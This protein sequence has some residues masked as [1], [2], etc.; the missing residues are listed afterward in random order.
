ME[1]LNETPVKKPKSK[2]LKIILLSLLAFI[3]LLIIVAFITAVTSSPEENKARDER[4]KQQEQK[5]HLEE[6]AEKEKEKK[7]EEEEEEKNRKHYGKMDALIQSQVYIETKLKSP[8][9]A[10]FDSSIDG[11]I[12]TNDTTFTVISYVDSQN[13][14]G[15]LLR[16]H[17]SC[18]IIFHPKD[19]THDI[20]NAVIK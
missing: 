11:V 1:Q 12:Q 4:I 6:K 14:Y 8:G 9:S 2:L 20:E 3:A 13:G 18:K 17:Y 7:A 5:E 16:T 10:K 15:A 19:D